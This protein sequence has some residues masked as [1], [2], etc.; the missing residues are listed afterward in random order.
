ML[1]FRDLAVRLIAVVAAIGAVGCIAD[2]KGQRGST[3]ED[4]YPNCGNSVADPGEQCDDGNR[5]GGDGCEA[6][7]QWTCDPAGLNGGKTAC[8]D[9]DPCNGEET[10]SSGHTCAAGTAPANGTTCGEA[11]ECQDGVCV[12]QIATCGD[13]IVQE[14]EECDANGAANDPSCD[15]NCQWRCIQGDLRRQCPDSLCHIPGTSLCQP[16]HSCTAATVG[17]DYAVCP[18]QDSICLNGECVPCGDGVVQGGTGEECDLGSDNGPNSGCEKNCKFSCSLTAAGDCAYASNPCFE[19]GSSQCEQVVV[20]GQT[21]NRCSQPTFKNNGDDCDPVGGALNCVSGSCVPTVCGDGIWA[22][23][24]ETCDDGNLNQRDGCKVDCSLTCRT[25]SDC[26]AS[27]PSTPA[28][29]T[30]PVCNQTE[31]DQRTGCYYVASQIGGACSTN[32]GSGR[33]VEVVISP[34]NTVGACTSIN[35]PGTCGNGVQESGEEC[36]AGSGNG[37]NTGCERTC[38]F[39]CHSHPDC[40]DT[41]PCNGTETCDATPAGKKCTYPPSSAWLK[42]GTSCG[43]SGSNRICLGTNF[44]GGCRKAACG[45]GFVT[46]TEECDPPNTSGCDATCRRTVQCDISNLWFAQNTEMPASWGQNL[47]SA[48]TY[49]GKISQLTL[50]HAI[51]QSGVDPPTFDLDL[52]ICGLK[53]PDFVSPDV[54]YQNFGTAEV[55]GVSFPD[56]IWDNWIPAPEYWMHATLAAYSLAPGGFLSLG[57]ISLPMGAWALDGKIDQADWPF[58]DPSTDPFLFLDGLY[59]PWEQLDSDQ[60]GHPG[61]TVVSKSGTIPSTSSAYS[62][63][64]AVDPT[65]V[66]HIKNNITQYS[67]VIAGILDANGNVVSSINDTARASNIYITVRALTNATQTYAA[68]FK[69]CTEIEGT[70]T[71]RSADNH[72]VGC[73][74]DNGPAGEPAEPCNPIEIGILDAGTPRFVMGSGSFTAKRIAAPPANLWATGACQLARDQFPNQYP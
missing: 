38:Q 47:A 59:N 56:A 34:T 19:P 65:I 1:L 16:D 10:C 17:P 6:T 37:Q 15:S 69:S 12:A 32:S 70:L 49:T 8:S 42:D 26:S 7:C 57:N 61:I 52:R 20:N 43:A 5:A 55:F 30:P 29:L 2:G 31:C 62:G 27:T 58:G 18:A 71:V 74:Q 40:D 46:G 54:I 33:C 44:F 68:K 51:Q 9:G 14:T 66:N 11:S 39:S 45:D 48:A 36:D 72:V 13:G 41:D 67:K 64:N 50:V 53:I 22:R 73:M 63:Q 60:D 21:V 3:V 25:A 28:L 35:P 4:F 24:N 23:A